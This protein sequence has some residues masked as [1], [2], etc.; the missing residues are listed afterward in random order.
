MSLYKK[1]GLPDCNPVSHKP[2]YKTAFNLHA[3]LKK[4]NDDY[5]LSPIREIYQNPLLTEGSSG[6]YVVSSRKQQDLFNPENIKKQFSLNVFENIS[7]DKIAIIFSCPAINDETKEFWKVFEHVMDRGRVNIL[8]PTALYHNTIM[9]CE[10]F[11]ISW[12]CRQNKINHIRVEFNPNKAEIFMLE[13]FFVAL[14]S[15]AL[16]YATVSRLDVAIDY[17]RY[18]NPLCWRCANV[19]FSQYITR[20]DI[21][22]TRYFGSKKSD[23]QIRLYDK[24]TEHF[25][26]T[27]N[28]LDFDFW[29]IEAEIHKIQGSSF[30]LV[31][32]DTVAGFNPFK[33]LDYIDPY[34]FNADGQGAYSSFVKCARAYGVASAISDY[35][36]RTRKKYLA[37]LK[38][39]TVNLPFNL[40]FDI[41]QNCFRNVYTRFVDRISEMFNNVQKQ[42]DV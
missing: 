28:K 16:T 42:K 27:G 18:L 20:S 7:I 40:P 24:A 35:D 13:L 26:T 12:G 17:A 41:Y 4:S 10:S 38:N 19:S 30:N 34:G 33:N 1:K 2:L 39:D 25:E 31:D 23:L 5:R 22:E 32:I 21:L 15:H 29:R 36:Y 11:H 6:I 8:G 9:W 37:R 14:K 3:E